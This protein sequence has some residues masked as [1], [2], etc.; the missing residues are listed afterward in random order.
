MLHGYLVVGSTILWLILGTLGPGSM[1]CWMVRWLWQR[2][3][4]LS[5]SA[6]AG[7][8]KQSVSRGDVILSA[9]PISWRQECANI[10]FKHS[11]TL[12]SWFGGRGVY[13]LATFMILIYYSC[14]CLDQLGIRNWALWKS[15]APYTKC[16]AYDTSVRTARNQALSQL[17][18][19]YIQ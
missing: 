9:P 8:L 5:C 13:H 2:S 17:C 3:W 19:R 11:D 10:N 1:S 14:D 6:V 18:C 12:T 15:L 16:M 7:F 4:V